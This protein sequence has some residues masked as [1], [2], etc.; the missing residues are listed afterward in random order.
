MTQVGLQKHSVGCIP[1]TFGLIAGLREEGIVE[2]AAVE[3]AWARGGRLPGM[4]AECSG[5]AEMGLYT[6]G[7]GADVTGLGA[8]EQAEK[9]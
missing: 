8:R 1:P 9:L 7:S 4:A 3:R 2:G 6:M 5:K